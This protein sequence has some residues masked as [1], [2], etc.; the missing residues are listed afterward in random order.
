MSEDTLYCLEDFVDTEEG[1]NLVLSG[2]VAFPITVQSALHLIKIT[3]T[4]LVYEER[5]F[6]EALKKKEFE[7]A[8]QLVERNIVPKDT[9]LIYTCCLDGS[10]EVLA[11]ALYVLQMEEVIIS[12]GRWKHSLCK[13]LHE[14]F[15]RPVFTERMKKMIN[16]L[17]TR[18]DI[19]QPYRHYTKT[20]SLFCYMIDGGLVTA[21]KVKVLMD[22]R[23]DFSRKYDNVSGLSRLTHGIEVNE[24]INILTL[25]K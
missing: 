13:C 14:L 19:N 15:V 12:I 24:F 20:S 4:D 6:R 22:V 3:K 10:D 8:K 21:E 9:D 1:R 5:L 7:Y 23:F 17:S 16:V 11:I 2:S 25:F 18:C